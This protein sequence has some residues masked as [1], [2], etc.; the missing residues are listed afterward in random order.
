MDDRKETPGDRTVLSTGASR[1]S[2]AACAESSAPSSGS[3]GSVPSL[4]ELVN[5]NQPQHLLELAAKA[6]RAAH[7]AIA[8]VSAEGDLHEHVTF[9]MDQ[10]VA[11]ELWR[12]GWGSE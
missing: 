3:G 4:H 10:D 11:L 8:L 1:K 7:G 12:S 5:L 9:G 6:V 2:R